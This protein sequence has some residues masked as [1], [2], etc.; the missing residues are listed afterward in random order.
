MEFIWG[1]NIFQK[2][3]NKLMERERD[4]GG[5]KYFSKIS[6]LPSPF[7]VNWT[8]PLMPF[9]LCMIAHQQTDMTR[10]QHTSADQKGIM[11]L[12]RM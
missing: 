5:R 7:K 1:W 8:P 12:E 2:F 3:L 6:Y 4:F 11:P 10:P 9:L